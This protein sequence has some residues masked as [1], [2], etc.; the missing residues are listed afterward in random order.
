MRG[1]RERQLLLRVERM[2]DERIVHH[3][4]ALPPRLHDD[5]VPAGLQQRVHDGY[6]EPLQP[7]GR[8]SA[9]CTAACY[10]DGGAERDATQDG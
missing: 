2:R 8:L 7:S 1:V 4:R 3:A 9:K 10:G 5:R 6:G